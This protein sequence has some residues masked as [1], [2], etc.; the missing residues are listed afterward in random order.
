[1]SKNEFEILK[2][3]DN[4]LD[5]LIKNTNLSKDKILH[6]LTLLEEKKLIEI[7]KKSAQKYLIK[8]NFLFLEKIGTPK[9]IILN[10]IRKGEKKT[11]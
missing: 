9:F 4:E 7:K 10:A 11:K 5:K 8:E 3:F 1:M 6:T 2:N